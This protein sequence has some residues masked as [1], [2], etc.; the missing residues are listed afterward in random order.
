MKEM[1]E[2]LKE[3][4]VLVAVLFSKQSATLEDIQ[5]LRNLAGL[6]DYYR[7]YGGRNGYNV[8]ERPFV[9]ALRCS[10]AGC[11]GGMPF[12]NLRKRSVEP[13]HWVCLAHIPDDMSFP[14]G[15]HGDDWGKTG[16]KP[17]VWGAG[18]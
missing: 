16:R 10:F 3:L 7:I 5:Q 18:R 14:I 11:K 6:L 9:G 2:V 4:Y 1:E 17:V 8:L 13:D 12:F 15:L